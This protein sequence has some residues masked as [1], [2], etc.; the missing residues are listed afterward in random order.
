MQV[1]WRK[2]LIKTAVWLMSEILFNLMGIDDLVDYSEFV[3]E[4]NLANKERLILLI[5]SSTMA[6]RRNSR[7]GKKKKLPD[8]QEILARAQKSN[9][10]QFFPSKKQQQ[11]STQEQKGIHTEAQQHKKEIILRLAK[12]A[13]PKVL[14]WVAL[15]GGYG[16]LISLLD[17][18]ELL[19]TIIYN[20]AIANVVISLTL[21]LGLLLVHKIGV[22]RDRF[23][24]GRKLWG[25][26]VN[27]IRN[28]VRGIWLYVDEQ[29]P[30][31]RYEKES[32]MHLVTAFAVATKLHLCKRPVEELKP[33]VSQL[34]YKRLQVSNHAPLDITFWIG[35]YLQRQYEQ[36]QLN[37][38]QFSDLQNCIDEMVNILGNCERIAT[39]PV[40]LIRDVTL[41]VLLTAYLV[42]FPLGMI[43]GLGWSTGLVMTFVSFVYL[44]IDEVRANLETP[45]GN[46]Q[47]DLYLDYVCDKIGRNVSALIQ[48]PSRPQT[49]KVVIN[50]P[51]KAA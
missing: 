39:T 35:D 31:D 17:R 21:T 49:T 29:E 1:K 24:K 18:W 48:Q 13:I 37:L 14:P 8:P 6:T 25:A 11:E 32:T 15:C 30:Q 5:K 9:I 43:G 40:Y 12:T 36:E 10:L 28:T 46:A 38:F 51:K 47:S 27:A 2:L 4:Q 7:F 26:M 45:F 34:E 3:F 33:L 41:K 44:S 42:I 23:G 16:F 19:P 50:L 22:A 20:Q